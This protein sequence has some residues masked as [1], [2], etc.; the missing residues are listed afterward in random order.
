[1]LTSTIH[2]S[3]FQFPYLD[4]YKIRI[5]R[6]DIININLEFLGGRESC[7]LSKVPLTGV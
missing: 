7:I 4:L 3:Y 5:I 2:S 1:M 6:A